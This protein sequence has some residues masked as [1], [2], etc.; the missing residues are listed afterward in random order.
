MKQSEQ[1]CKANLEEEVGAR[2]CCAL[3]PMARVL[4]FILS[5][6]VPRKGFKLGSCHANKD[7]KC[8]GTAFNS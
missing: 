6:L 4:M 1:W 7:T 8:A 2:S 3:D 5:D